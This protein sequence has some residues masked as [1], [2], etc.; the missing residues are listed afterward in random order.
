MTDGT[1]AGDNVTDAHIVNSN[2]KS[3]VKKKN[4]TNR[5]A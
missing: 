5:L 1:I 3:K 2:I 4:W